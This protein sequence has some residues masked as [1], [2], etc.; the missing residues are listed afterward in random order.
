L[1]FDIG[2]PV[3]K[4]ELFMCLRANTVIFTSIIIDE[5]RPLQVLFPFWDIS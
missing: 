2:D 4:T 1:G 5:A 3:S